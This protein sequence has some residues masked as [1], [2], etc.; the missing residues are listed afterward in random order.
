MQMMHQIVA[1]HQ[2]IFYMIHVRCTLSNKTDNVERKKKMQHAL[3]FKN[4]NN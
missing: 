4:I 1:I 3:Q 2:K